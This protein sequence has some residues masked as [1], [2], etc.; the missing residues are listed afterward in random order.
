[1]G[2]T[3][4][5]PQGLPAERMIRFVVFLAMFAASVLMVSAPAAY[6]SS[7]EGKAEG[8]NSAGAVLP[9]TVFQLEKVVTTIV[10]PQDHVM[11]QIV[12]DI[13]LDL[14]STAH[15][16]LVSHLQPKLLNAF[17]RDFQ[18]YFY[19]DTKYR[20]E[21]LAKGQRGFRYE[22]P[23]LLEP[24][25]PKLNEDGEEVHE[26]AKDGEEAKP[27]FN[28]FQPTTNKVIAVLQAR[29]LATCNRVLGEG[30]VKSVQVRA[31]FDQWPNER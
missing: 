17:L 6:A 23:R 10:L 25:K 7:G 18:R 8:G 29:L 9:G 27:P 16:D 4:K 1:M 3:P 15:R 19:R 26:E 12:S 2:E 11:R 28:P 21:K 20:A 22:A 24:P 30:I 31:L 14:S 5:V 13:W